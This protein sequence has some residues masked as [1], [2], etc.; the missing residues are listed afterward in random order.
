MV[1]SPPM[2]Q[3]LSDERSHV[4]SAI[5]PRRL[6]KTVGTPRNLVTPYRSIL[7]RVPAGSKRPWMTMVAPL[8]RMGDAWMKSPPEWNR[9]RTISITSSK[10]SLKKISAL[11][12]LKKVFRC[13][14]TA[15]LGWPVVPEVY[16]ITCG[17][18][19]SAGPRDF[20]R[21]GR[22]P[23]RAAVSEA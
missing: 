18:S 5:S 19:G 11:R 6:R 13:D 7:R 4:R 10:W 21:N 20:V 9:G 16:M 3:T 12:Q 14:R 22:R 23:S 1:F 17:S 2:A 15:P 8:Y